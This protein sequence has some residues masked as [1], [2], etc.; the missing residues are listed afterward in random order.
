MRNITLEGKIL[1]SKMLALS[2][3][4]HLTLGASFSKQLIKEI[5]KM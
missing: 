5:Q 3:I 4:V 1:I 2:K